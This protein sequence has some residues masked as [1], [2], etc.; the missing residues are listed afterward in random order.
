MHELSIMMEV[1]K[2]VERVA[3]ENHVEKVEKIVLQVGEMASVI[4]RYLEEV[5][6]AAVYQTGLEGAKL[7]LEILP[8][9]GRCRQCGKVFSVMENGGTCSCGS[10][11]VELLT[12]REFNLK[13]IQVW[14]EEE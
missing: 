4:P 10:D 1:V 5:F 9:N 2:Q 11:D 13:E 3:K 12:G 8:A 7:E 6:P 14:E